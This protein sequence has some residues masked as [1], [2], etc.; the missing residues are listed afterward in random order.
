[1]QAEAGLVVRADPDKAGAAF[2]T[3]S[4]TGREALTQLGRALGV[5]RGDGPMRQP[6]PDLDDVPALVE[7]ARPAGLQARLAERGQRRPVP[8]DLAAAVYRVVQEALT[9]TVRHAHARRVA[10]RLDWRDTSLRVEVVDDGDGP[11]PP[12]GGSG[13]GLAGMRER[14]DAFGG[15]LRTGA[16]DS[17]V[18]FRVTAIL[19]LAAA[20]T[21]QGQPDD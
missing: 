8:A 19:P 6:Q 13:R 1:V 18:G 3:I 21:A 10:V 16:G 14:V 7:R 4:A 15:E 12:G 17:G 5:L 20:A 11:G 2:D 9:N